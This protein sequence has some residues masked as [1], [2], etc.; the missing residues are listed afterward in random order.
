VF[1]LSVVLSIG[2]AAPKFLDELRQYAMALHTKEQ[3]PGSGQAPAPK[4][5]KP[6]V[7]TKAGY[8][9][10]MEESKVVYD[11]FEDIV[12]NDPRYERL[13]N[14]G[15]ERGPALDEDIK[16]AMSNWGLQRTPSNSNSPGAVYAAKLRDL[17]KS[18]PPA[19]VCHYYNYYF[20]HT[21][22]GRMIGKQ[23]SEA[24]LDGWMGKFY[25][26]E[27]TV[28]VLLN[29]VRDILNEMAE[30][31]NEEEKRASME[32]TPETFKMAGSLMRLMASQE[33]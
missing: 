29:G 1:S 31:W 13:R 30:D 4:E 24:A 19:F 5:K 21:A 27:G 9:R 33:K 18:N 12:A 20:A 25:Q 3:A 26:W 32:E 6:F 15:L 28:S 23:V 22:G 17:A 11:A 16:Y 14:N 10:F 7:P 8:F 2:L